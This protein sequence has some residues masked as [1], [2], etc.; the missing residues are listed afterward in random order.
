MDKAQRAN[1]IR[2][3]F[4]KLGGKLLPRAQPKPKEYRSPKAGRIAVASLGEAKAWSW[5]KTEWL[6]AADA[7]KP[8]VVRIERKKRASPLVE[9]AKKWRTFRPRAPEVR[10]EA[11]PL[12]LDS[13][14]GQRYRP[15]SQ[16]CSATSGECGRSCSASCG[17]QWRARGSRLSWKTHS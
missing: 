4:R 14:H 16:E 13:K 1:L 6:Q 5:G 9:I 17:A 15:A 3:R 8:I 10:Q 12:L 7:P 2:E 11:Q